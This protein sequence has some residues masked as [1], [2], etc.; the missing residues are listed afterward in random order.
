MILVFNQIVWRK[1]RMVWL[2]P[3][4]RHT[5]PE[6]D[7]AAWLSIKEE[8]GFVLQQYQPHMDPEGRF[9][10]EKPFRIIL[11][12]IHQNLLVAADDQFPTI[13]D[14][15]EWLEANIF[16]QV[17]LLSDLSEEELFQFAVLKIS[18]LVKCSEIAD[19]LPQ[20]RL[21][22]PEQFFNELYPNLTLIECKR[23]IFVVFTVYSNRPFSDC[24][25]SLWEQMLYKG[26]IFLSSKHIFFYSESEQKSF[27]LPFIE[28][29]NVR[30]NF[31]GMVPNSLEIT[32][33]EDNKVS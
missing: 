5:T 8:E 19:P 27:V 28:I 17:R 10:T 22:S 14:H 33:I 1:E 11:R 12:A 32:T 16:A 26:V 18:S 20:N 25:C 30:Q 2:D 29:S 21:A 24:N 9:F 6:D 7:R 23:H 31:T 15:W 13:I 3:T 4:D